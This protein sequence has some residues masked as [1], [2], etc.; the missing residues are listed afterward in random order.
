MTIYLKT[1]IQRNPILY[2]AAI[3]VKGIFAA[4]RYNCVRHVISTWT[5][6]ASSVVVY[7]ELESHLQNVENVISEISREGK[8]KI[9]LVLGFN[10]SHVDLKKMHG[11]KIVKA[12][13]RS[14]MA[15]MRA[16]IFITPCV[17]FRRVTSPVGSRIIHF[18]IS[19]TSLD[20]VYA[21]HHFDDYDYIFC[22]GRHQISDFSRWSKKNN[23]GG[24][25]LIRGGY[26]KLD[27]QIERVAE[28]RGS[29]D[30]KIAEKVVIYAPTHVYSINEKLASFRRH[31]EEI[32]R[33][34]LD[35]GFLV[36]FRP[37]PVSFKDED[38]PLVAKICAEHEGNSRFV[39]DASKNYIEA[40]ANADLMVTDLSGTGFTFAFTFQRP[41]IFFAAD[42]QAE[43]GLDGIQFHR[44]HEIGSVVRNIHELGEQCW[45]LMVN[46]VEMEK[47]IAQFRDETI[48]NLGTSAKYFCECLP[49][50]ERGEVNKDWVVS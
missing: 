16:R 30:K 45:S 10:P 42:A 44:R 35:S 21:D 41:V 26:P 15:I 22:A 4:V 36:I 49:F 33:T 7:C 23:W 14:V 34:L 39:L 38:K 2:K 18:L 48:F 28:W 31:G 27:A 32:L 40:Y 19:L 37:H 6:A 43:A 50:I 13:S 20:G 47:K 25:I 3:C 29:K 5:F 24:K 17:G 46:K 1:K 9:I 11:V 12:P 8:K